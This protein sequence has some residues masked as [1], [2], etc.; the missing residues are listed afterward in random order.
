M[1]PQLYTNEVPKYI[2]M[3]FPLGINRILIRPKA[4]P[5]VQVL[6]ARQI[7]NTARGRAK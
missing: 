6:W 7:V 2:P 4:S 5:Q 3:R 1:K